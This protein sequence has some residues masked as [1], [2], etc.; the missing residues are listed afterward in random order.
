MG[1]A[2]KS[3]YKKS[4]LNYMDCF[5]FSFLEETNENDKKSRAPFENG[6]ISEED[7]EYIKNNNIEP[8]KIAK[9][10][11]GQYHGFPS[12]IFY[13]HYDKKELR[14][15]CLIIIHKSLFA[16]WGYD[17]DFICTWYNFL[18]NIPKFLE[19]IN[20]NVDWEKLYKIFIEFIE[21]SN[22]PL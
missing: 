20:Y 5:G 11:D 3:K 6:Y 21:Q 13:E 9:Y 7:L 8:E 18:G 14:E 15:K 2:L 17:S 16:K 10:C 1:N 12:T 4:I 19:M 22:I